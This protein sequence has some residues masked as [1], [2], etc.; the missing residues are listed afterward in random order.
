MAFSE[1]WVVLLWLLGRNLSSGRSLNEQFAG[2]LEHILPFL[3]LSSN[4]LCWVS[5][6][7]HG[8]VLQPS[9]L[10]REDSRCSDH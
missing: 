7:A 5:E 9:H 2:D 6:M 3:P 4:G 10:R 1:G 8:L